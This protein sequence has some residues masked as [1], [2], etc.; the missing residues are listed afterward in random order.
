MTFSGLKNNTKASISFFPTGQCA[1]RFCLPWYPISHGEGFLWAGAPVCWIRDHLLLQRGNTA[2]LAVT[3]Y[4]FVGATKGL[5]IFI[6]DCTWAALYK[7]LFRISILSFTNQ[8]IY[9]SAY[10]GLLGKLNA[11]LYLLIDQAPL[12]SRAVFCLKM[13]SLTWEKH[14]TLC[15]ITKGLTFITVQARTFF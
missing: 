11:S 6:P 8:C 13:L 5:D 10:F 7:F 14:D 2:N 3:T 4:P 1:Q 12:L 15:D 9:P